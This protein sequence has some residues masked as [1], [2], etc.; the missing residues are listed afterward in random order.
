M[1]EQKRWKG[2]RGR[3]R[4]DSNGATLMVAYNFEGMML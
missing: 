4:W 3:G 1:V 2:D